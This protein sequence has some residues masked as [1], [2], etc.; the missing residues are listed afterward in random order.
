MG[1]FE[2]IAVEHKVGMCFLLLRHHLGDELEILLQ[3]VPLLGRIIKVDEATL[4]TLLVV[5]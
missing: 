3:D 4:S 1:A 5:G 2:T